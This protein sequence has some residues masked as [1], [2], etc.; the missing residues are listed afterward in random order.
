LKALGKRLKMSSTS[1]SVSVPASGTCPAVFKS[2]AKKDQVCGKPGKFN[3]FCGVHKAK[4]AA[5]S[6]GAVHEAKS[7]AGSEQL[8]RKTR[9]TLESELQPEQEALVAD[10]RT[11]SLLAEGLDKDD[12]SVVSE[13]VEAK[14]A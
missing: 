2:G 11:T 9:S 12:D 6:D 3:G 1:S 13:P 10:N 5:G 4:P 14:E 8:V 7:V